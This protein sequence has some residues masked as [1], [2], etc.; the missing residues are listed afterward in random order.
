MA[1]LVIIFPIQAES[2]PE[3]FLMS[4]HNID[5]ELYNATV[6]TCIYLLFVIDILPKKDEIEKFYSSSI[7]INH[8]HR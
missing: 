5:E 6:F 2:I 1:F 4:V 7:L 3:Q 8:T